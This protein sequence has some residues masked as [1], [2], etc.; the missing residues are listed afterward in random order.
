[1][2]E[3]QY[4]LDLPHPSSII[5]KL[6]QD[7]GIWHDFAKPMVIAIDVVNPGDENG[8]GLIRHVKYKLP[9]GLKGKSIETVHDVVIGVGYTY[10]TL[11]GTEGRIRL[12]QLSVDKTRLHFQEKLKLNWPFSWFESPIQ[13]FMEKYNRKTMLNM[14][15]W[16]TEHP[17][18]RMK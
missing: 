2:K 15:K 12:E 16:L 10:T 13:H 5:W 14:S 7:Y 18:Y 17:E 4:S 9:F 6:L 11:K 1:M 3:Y 8:N